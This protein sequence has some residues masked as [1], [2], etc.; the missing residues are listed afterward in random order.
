VRALRA[1]GYRSWAVGKQHFRPHRAD[2][3]FDE[4][5]LGEPLARDG[6]DYLDYLDSVGYGWVDEPWGRRADHYYLP[7]VSVLPHEHHHTTWTAEQAIRLIE[8]PTSEPFVGVVGFLKPHPPFDPTVPFTHMYRPEELR[9][10]IDANG[11]LRSFPIEVAQNHMKWRDETSKELA[12]SLR[13]AY[14]ASVSQVDAE[15]GRILGAIEPIA[16]TTVVVFVADHGELLGDHGLW[17]KRSF[18]GGSLQ[19]PLIIRRPDETNP[20]RVVEDLVSQR[21]VGPTILGLAGLPVPQNLAGTDLFGGGPARSEA[22]VAAYG[23]GDL[24]V[25]A[26]LTTTHRWS[27][28][29]AG[30]RQRLFDL[31]ADP[32]ET[33]NLVEN[34]PDHPTAAAARASVEDELGRRGNVLG[35]LDDGGRLRVAALETVRR[36]FPRNNQ[37]GRRG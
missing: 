31:R 30:G 9:A 10:P 23:T 37:R 6:D 17:G 7:Q 2:H 3:G 5:V 21:D 25:V 34:D 14:F 20:G 19:I 28:S 16:R 18:L 35:Y 26:H 11:S 8:R 32:E 13:A 29:L 15:I 12:L 4:L 36:R 33:Q 24:G 22:L 27:Y 1:A